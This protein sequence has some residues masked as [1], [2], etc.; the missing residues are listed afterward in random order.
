M[1][2][3]MAVP[4]L[5]EV[6]E[7]RRKLRPLDVREIAERFGIQALTRDEIV[8]LTAELVVWL[9]QI[10]ESKAPSRAAEVRRMLEQQDDVL[11]RPF[12]GRV[13]G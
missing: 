7:E 12:A 2:R 8:R 4:I 11:R 3:E 9:E 10:D 1:S 5:Q 13:A 6:L